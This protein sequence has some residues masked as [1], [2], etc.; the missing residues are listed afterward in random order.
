MMLLVMRVIKRCSVSLRVTKTVTRSE[1]EA[2]AYE[3]PFG[4]AMPTHARG[5]DQGSID[6]ESDE[7]EDIEAER[8]ARAK[9]M[10]KRR[11]CKRQVFSLHVP[12]FGLCCPPS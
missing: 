12:V 9:L 10:L 7:E 4:C 1:E 8:K 3:K 11:R 2:V 6:E 5:S